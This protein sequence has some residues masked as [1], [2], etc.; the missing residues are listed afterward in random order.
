MRSFRGHKVSRG[1]RVV[2]KE[3]YDIRP[4][5]VLLYQGKRYRARGVHNKGTRVILD[6]GKSVAAGK[7]KAPKSLLIISWG[8]GIIQSIDRRIRR[9]LNMLTKF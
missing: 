9:S 5:T 2:R 1:R 3:R 7:V 4:G 8:K 6:N